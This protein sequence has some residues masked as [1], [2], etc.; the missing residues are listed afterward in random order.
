[1][2]VGTSWVLDLRRNSGGAA[3][4]IGE[5]LGLFLPRGEALTIQRRTG[6]DRTYQ[7]A[8]NT[9]PVQRPLAV[10]IG[11]GSASAAEIT[12]AALQDSGRAR[13]F[14]ERS[15]GCA[16]MAEVK[17]LSDG[18]GLFVTVAR[19]LAGPQR[20]PLEG[21]GVTPDETVEAYAVSDPALAAASRFLATAAGRAQAPAPVGP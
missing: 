15:A 4:R 14:G 3:E 18:S 6:R 11:Q 19:V 8:A 1:V 20:R 2:T 5:V 21:V 17:S 10:L 7:T 16:N 13:V 9:L 12:A